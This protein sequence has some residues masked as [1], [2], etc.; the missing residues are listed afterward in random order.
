MKNNKRD[1]KEAAKGLV[2]FCIRNN[3]VLEDYHAE[4]VPITDERIKQFMKDCVNNV[5]YVL[6][7]LCE[8][9]DCLLRYLII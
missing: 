3:T 6:S 9:D 7:G 1:I 2:A 8:Y 5:Y 4:Q